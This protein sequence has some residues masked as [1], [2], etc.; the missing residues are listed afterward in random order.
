[1]AI[2][3][4]LRIKMQHR[5]EHLQICSTMTILITSPFNDCPLLITYRGDDEPVVTLLATSARIKLA[6]VGHGQRTLLPASEYL[7]HLVPSFVALCMILSTPV[8]K[9][10]SCPT[11]WRWLLVH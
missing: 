11:L 4:S 9:P 1:M 3:L 5:E 6:V 10:A 7:C 2:T 8:F